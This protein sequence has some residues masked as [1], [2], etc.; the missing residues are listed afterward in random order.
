MKKC[1]LYIILIVGILTACN[2]GQGNTTPK[3]DDTFA[4]KSRKSTFVLDTTSTKSP[5][6]DCALSIQTIVSDN[7]KREEKINRAIQ[8]TIFGSEGNNID[9]AIDTLLAAIRSDYN[10]M[11]PEYIN[12]KHINESAEWFNFTYNLKTKVDYGYDGTI[13]YEIRCYSRNGGSKP[14]EICTYLNFDPLSGD[15]IH[16][17]DIFKEGYEEYLCNR[18]TDAL[19]DIIGANSRQEIKAK[20]YLNFNDIYP[21]ENFQ[22]GRDSIHFFYNPYDIA[23]PEQGTTIIGFAYEE[24]SDILNKPFKQ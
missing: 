23:P 4:E 7:K 24:L 13:I 8:Y 16:L 6:Y 18:L 15:E 2:N 20:G 9:A 11:R 5:R 3:T 21:T 14:S 19:A 1:V 12:E 10:D 22:L 17:T